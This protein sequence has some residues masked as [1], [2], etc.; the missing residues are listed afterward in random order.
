MSVFPV[1]PDYYNI[2]QE[3]LCLSYILTY[4]YL[5]QCVSHTHMPSHS[6][7]YITYHYIH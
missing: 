6:Y 5:F 4:I 2:Y 7:I 3:I 1:T